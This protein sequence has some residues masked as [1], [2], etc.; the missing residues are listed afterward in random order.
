MKSVSRIA[1]A[2]VMSVTFIVA[3]PAAQAQPG[4]ETQVNAIVNTWF[5]Y[6]TPANRKL[7]ASKPLQVTL[8]RPQQTHL[9]ALGA[10]RFP[11]FSPKEKAGKLWSRIPSV[12]SYFYKDTRGLA[13][14]LI[15]KDGP[16]VRLYKGHYGRHV[17]SGGKVFDVRYSKPRKLRLNFL[18]QKM[19]Q[20]VAQWRAKRMVRAALK[21]G[22]APS[23]RQVRAAFQ[24][25]MPRA[26]R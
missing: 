1:C 18:P 9:P 13:T 25:A 19:R 8:G 24:S 26:R 4:L 3:V 16:A 20:K 11:V 17:P 22:P 2:A 10:G 6:D 23:V 14:M 12:D 7:A 15:T 21:A 5:S